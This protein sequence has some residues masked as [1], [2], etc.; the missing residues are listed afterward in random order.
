MKISS[1]KAK[2]RKLQNQIRDDLQA[3]FPILEPD[4]IQSQIM[5]M[6]GA[7]IVL[8]PAARKII[9]YSIECKNQERLNL[10]DSLAQAESNAGEGIPLLIFKRN[11]SKTY[12]TIEWTNFLELIKNV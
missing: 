11:R 8:S 4:D 3:A 5:G 6:S 9:K 12:A 2:G 1:R 7:D 10:W